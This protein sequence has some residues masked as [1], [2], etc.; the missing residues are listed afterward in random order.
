MAEIMVIG[1]RAEQQKNDFI[2]SVV[3]LSN[4]SKWESVSYS[5]QKLC[6]ENLHFLP[7]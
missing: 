5:T 7:M 4:L 1:G 3:V 2:G 6:W